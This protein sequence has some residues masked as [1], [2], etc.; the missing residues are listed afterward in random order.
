MG[1]RVHVEK[2]W[3]SHSMKIWLARSS[4]DGSS[5][6]FMITPTMQSIKE[7]LVAPAEPTLKLSREEGHDFLQACANAAWE[8]GIQPVQ[9][10]DSRKELEAVRFHLDDMRLLAKVRAR[11]TPDA[12]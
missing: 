8:Q 4:M 3:L 1:W 6:D 7:G 10:H 9:L 2:E 12:R 5:T 11:A